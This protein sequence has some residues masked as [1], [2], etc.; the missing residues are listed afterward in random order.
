MLKVADSIRRVRGIPCIGYVVFSSDKI[1]DQGVAGYRKYRTRDSV[2]INDRFYLG[3][4]TLVLLRLS[5][6]NW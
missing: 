1:I 6:P 5:L 3:T 2:S 4:N